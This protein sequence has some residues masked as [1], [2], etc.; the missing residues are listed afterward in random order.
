MAISF[1]NGDLM[2]DNNSRLSHV[3][4]VHVTA[5]KFATG[6]SVLLEQESI[7]SYLDSLEYLLIQQ[8]NELRV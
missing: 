1:L 2:T 8:V 6:F 7:K 4:K 3:L 5:K